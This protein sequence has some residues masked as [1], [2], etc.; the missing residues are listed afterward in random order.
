MGQPRDEDPS[1]KPATPFTTHEHFSNQPA[2]D[3]RSHRCRGQRPGFI[4]T[5]I[6]R[7][8]SL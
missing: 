8:G 2:L 1:A 3:V 7:A 5:S 6:W 4:R